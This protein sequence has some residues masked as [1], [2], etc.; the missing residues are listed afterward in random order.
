MAA[1]AD[2]TDLPVDTLTVPDGAARG[3]AYLARMAAGLESSLN[4][5]SRW[6][7]IGRRVDPDPA[8]VAPTASR[9]RR[10]CE[11]GTGA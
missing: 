5:S 4:E 3:A 8:W 10:F 1:V 6:A 7:S 9:Y 11:L 2:A